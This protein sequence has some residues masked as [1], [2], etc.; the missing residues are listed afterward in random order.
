MVHPVDVNVAQENVALKIVEDRFADL[1]FL[2]C[3]ARVCLFL[4]GV[5]HLFGGHVREFRRIHA[6]WEV[7]D[8]H[9]A[10][11]QLVEV[12]R[13]RIVS[14][15]AASSQTVSTRRSIIAP[16]LSAMFSPRST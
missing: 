1:R 10:Q 8:L 7:E 13:F 16:M 5:A 14:P 6:V 3:V 4:E 15:W 2:L 12:P 11:R 9:Q